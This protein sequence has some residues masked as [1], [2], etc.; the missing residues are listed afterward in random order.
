MLME[1]TPNFRKV[2]LF[3][4]MNSLRPFFDWLSPRRRRIRKAVEKAEAEA[5]AKAEAEAK[6]AAERQEFK[7]NLPDSTP[8]TEQPK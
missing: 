8:S 3:S 4:K 1:N 7:V 2:K 6:A 5:K